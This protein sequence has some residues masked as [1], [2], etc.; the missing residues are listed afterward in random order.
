MVAKDE[1]ILSP[2]GER[3]VSSA[4]GVFLTSLIVQPLEVAKT[5]L[6]AQK[7]R[8]APPAECNECVPRRPQRPTTQLLLCRDHRLRGTRDTLRMVMRH[9]GARGLYAGLQP[10]LAMI[11]P[12]TMIYLTCY[13]ELMHLAP[14]SIESIAPMICGAS[15]RSFTATLVAPLELVRTQL[16]S[17]MHGEGKGVR[18]AVRKIVR[19][20]GYRGLWRGLGATLWRDVPFSALYWM[21]V[22]RTR[23]TLRQCNDAMRES[24]LVP[25]FVAGFV[26]GVGAAV[27]THPFDVVK[28]RVQTGE[29]SGNPMRAVCDL[30]Q[31]RGVKSAYVGLWPRLLRIGPACAVMVASY[32]LGKKFLR[33]GTL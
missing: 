11:V 19:N 15:A 8:C 17:G 16:Q 32:E 12:S 6:Q 13:D 14:E 9:Q 7:G 23:R 5:R 33:H 26:G 2:I 10:T 1:R 3:A 4:L 27:C 29:K 18:S 30:I 22:E 31:R 21:F 24:T 25:N 28:T 20:D